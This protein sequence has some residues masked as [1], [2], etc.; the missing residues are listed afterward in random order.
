MISNLSLKTT[1][2]VVSILISG[3]LIPYTVFASPIFENDSFKVG[4]G[5]EFRFEPEQSWSRI[6]TDV[7]VAGQ[8]KISSVDVVVFEGETLQEVY[9][10]FV[11]QAVVPKKN[12]S[13]IY[14]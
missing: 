4:P 8:G 5:P 10:L 6:T 12:L 11:D 13:C 3:I 7:A 14:K 1:V 9:I 2:L